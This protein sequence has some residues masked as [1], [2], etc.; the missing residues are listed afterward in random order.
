ML[1]AI[2]NRYQPLK[3]YAFLPVIG[4]AIS[5]LIVINVLTDRRKEI[6]LGSRWLWLPILGIAISMAGSGIVNG[7]TIAEK[8]TPAMF[9]MYL[10]GIYLGGRIFKGEMLKP[11]TWAMIIVSVS[12]VVYSLVFPGVPTGGLASPSSWTFCGNYDIA[13]GI[14]IFG[15]LVSV[16]RKQWWLSAIAV[17]G[18]MA[19]GATEAI[20]IVGVV[21][22]VGLIRRDWSLKV[23]LPA[24]ALVLFALI[25]VLS[26]HLTAIYGH[27]HAR[28]TIPGYEENMMIAASSPDIV[29]EFVAT[30]PIAITGNSESV[31]ELGS[32]WAVI[33]NAMSNIKLFGNG[34]SITKFTDDTVH[35]IPLIIVDQ[36]GILGALA[37]LV[38]TGYCLLRTKWT[39]AWVAV[40]AMGVFDHYIWT[41]VAPWWWMLAGVSS[42]TNINSDLIFRG[43]IQ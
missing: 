38:A 25:G 15:L 6:T 9:A 17:A 26:G 29:A 14:M 1:F 24:G 43:G 7:S 3:E 30:E 8:A 21:G 22:L 28:L 32:R 40:V 41:Q 31:T 34:Y 23:I 20:F 35:N 5:L 19:T 12:C 2:H 37:W 39:Y 36:V 42:N 11:F 13:S 10:V 16:V 33:S 18:I 4:L 27:N